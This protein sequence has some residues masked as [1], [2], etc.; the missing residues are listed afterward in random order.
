MNDDPG[1]KGAV[2]VRR[3]VRPDVHAHAAHLAVRR[4]REVGVVGAGAVLRVE[5]DEVVGL[6]A[7]AVVVDLE[8]ARGLVEAELV[9]QVVVLVGRIEELRD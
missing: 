6:A 8:V 1:L 2:P 9:Q 5:D 3:A 7:L 4:R